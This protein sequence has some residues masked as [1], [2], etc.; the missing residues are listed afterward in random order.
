MFR[1]LMAVFS[2]SHAMHLPTINMLLTNLTEFTGV[3]CSAT[4]SYRFF[5]E[6]QIA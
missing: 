2:E 5:L 6:R 3:V 4:Q 1:E